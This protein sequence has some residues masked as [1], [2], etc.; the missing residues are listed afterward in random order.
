MRASLA[1]VEYFRGPIAVNDNRQNQTEGNEILRLLGR[2]EATV[3][4]IQSDI[5]DLKTEAKDDRT[6]TTENRRRMHE[7]ME[8]LGRSVQQTDS[9]VRILGAL[10]DKQGKDIEGVTKEVQALAPKVEA[11]AAVVRRWTMRGGAIVAALSILAGGLWYLASTNWIALWR[12]V[13]QFIPK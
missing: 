12:F 11:T 1:T 5:T 9:T 3:T 8:S 10:V 2:L 13:D 6:S 4:A 7:K